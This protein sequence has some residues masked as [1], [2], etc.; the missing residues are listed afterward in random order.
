[1]KFKISCSRGGWLPHA[2]QKEKLLRTYPFLVAYE[3]ETSGEETYITINTLEELLSLQKSACS[4]EAWGLVLLPEN[5]DEPAEIE[6]YDDYR[7]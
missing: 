5:E 3:F 7:E 1:M 6:I 4:Y 2:E